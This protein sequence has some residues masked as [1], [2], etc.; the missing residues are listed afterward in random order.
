MSATALLHPRETIALSRETSRAFRGGPS[1]SP[2]RAAFEFYPTPPEATR[3][4]LSVESFDGSIWEPACG[5]G[6]ISSVLLEAGHQ[7]V[8]TDLIVRGFGEGRVDFLAQQSSRAK[9]IITNPPYGRGLADEFCKHLL[10]NSSTVD[11]L[12]KAR[13]I[14]I[15]IRSAVTQN[16]ACYTGMVLKVF[17]SLKFKLQTCRKSIEF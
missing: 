3:A 1:L 13:L 8:S 5:E 14:S 10:P 7:V 17:T 9:H 15:A 16:S 11:D 4:L 2:H 6:H 12:C